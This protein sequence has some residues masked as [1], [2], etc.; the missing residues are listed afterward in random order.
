[1]LPT[2][3][4]W[5][6]KYFKSRMFH[7][8]EKFAK[9]FDYLFYAQ[10][11]C[12]AKEVKDSLSVSLQNHRKPWLQ[13]KWRKI[14][15]MSHA[16]IGAVPFSRKPVAIQHFRHALYDL[17]GMIGQHGHC[18]W[19]IT[20]SAA[21]LTLSVS[22]SLSSRKAGA[23][24]MIPWAKC[25]GRNAVL[26]CDSVQERQQDTLLIVS[27]TSLSRLSMKKDRQI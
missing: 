17:L 12:E 4:D 18:I 11:W 9:N 5:H 6:E 15:L 21:D 10:Y 23:C 3:G 13:R 8:G 14:C 19:F 22:A 7:C 27:I 1:M 2:E 26:C 20:V 24:V 25:R 16:M